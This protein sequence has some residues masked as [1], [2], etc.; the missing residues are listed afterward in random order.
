[1][2]RV[3]G[4][5]ILTTV[6][7]AVAVIFQAIKIW[8][9]MDQTMSAPLVSSSPAL[10]TISPGESMSTIA[11]NLGDGGW[12][13]DHR[14]F[15]LRARIDGVAGAMQAGTYEIVSG[16]TP[17]ALLNRF[18]VGATKDFTVTFIEGSNFADMRRALKSQPH[19][20]QTINSKSESELSGQLAIDK[21]SLEGLFFPATYLYSVG[22][23]D[24][25]I[26]KRAHSKLQRVLNKAW[27]K[28]VK[29]LPFETPYEALIMASII[30][31]E[32]GQVQERSKIAGVL[33]RRLQKGMRL[34]TDPTVIYGMGSDFVGNL[35]RKDLVR[36]TP[37]NTYTRKGLPPTPIAMASAGAIDAAN[38]PDEEK[39]I[40]FVAKGDGTH[41]FSKTL[42]EHKA[43]VKRFQ[44]DK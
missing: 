9:E 4:Y 43:A 40:Y 41:Q 2:S 39:T 8:Q 33:I 3:A 34:Q 35:K 42:A 14:W 17:A 16:D 7:I 19:L 27:E 36:D 29:G 23:T 22:S 31:K 1:M 10:F 20:I 25:D 6:V 26:L 37:Y 13:S 15:E 30:E 18:Q 32:T 28:R 21:E 5:S 11:R 12:V 38:N 24:M 44:I